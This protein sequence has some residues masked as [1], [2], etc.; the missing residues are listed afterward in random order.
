[1]TSPTV[2]STQI[3]TEEPDTRGKH[4]SCSD[5]RP[6]VLCLLCLLPGYAAHLICTVEFPPLAPPTSDDN[7]DLF[8][9]F[10]ESFTDV[11]FIMELILNHL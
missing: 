2:L 10:S 11:S 3:Y 4:G 9:Q 1:M 8:S 6:E 5:Q 7:T